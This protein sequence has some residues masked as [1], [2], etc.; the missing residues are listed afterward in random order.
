MEQG[1]AV[2]TDG[3]TSRHTSAAVPLLADPLANGK[4]CAL[5]K[6]DHHLGNVIWGQSGVFHCYCSTGS[7]CCYG[8]SFILFIIHVI[9][10]N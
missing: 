10:L 6:G 9:E 1:K 8:V 2:R 5:F 4:Q 3:M 7:K